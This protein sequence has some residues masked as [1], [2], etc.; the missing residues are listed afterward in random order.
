M[1]IMKKRKL[2]LPKLFLNKEIISSL[3]QEKI[4]GGMSAPLV[5]CLE[6]CVLTCGCQISMND[7]ISC[8]TG[9]GNTV[10]C[11]TKMKCL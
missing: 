8:V 2:N 5:T 7:E 10:W 6:T 1:P 4:A 9:C 11:N 3:S